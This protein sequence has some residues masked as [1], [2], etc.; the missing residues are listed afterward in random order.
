MTDQEVTTDSESQRNVLISV[1]GSEH[2]K[3]AFNFYLNEICKNGDNVVVFHALEMPSLPAAPYPYGFAYYEE[4]QDV[5]KIA[6]EEAK[7][8]LRGFGDILKAKSDIKFKLVKEGGRPGELIC[9]NIKEEKI[10]LVIL[11]S[12]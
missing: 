11:G 2:S 7:V 4:W 12:R 10:K 9:K 3:R 6:D 5:T 8:L 1:D